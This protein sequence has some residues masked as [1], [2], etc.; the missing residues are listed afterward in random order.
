MAE[1]FKKVIRLLIIC[2]FIFLFIFIIS[3]AFKI[4]ARYYFKLENANI[5]EYYSDLYD[6][7]PYVI[8]AII[9]TESKF[10][11]YA[12]SHKGASGY[13]Q[14]MEQ[15]ADWGAEE[16]GIEDYSYDR[17]FE[18]EINIQIGTWYFSRLVEQ[19]GSVEV[20]LAAYNGGS[21]NVEKWLQD[22]RYSTDSKS[23]HTI[24]F[25]ETEKYVKRV[26]FAYRVYKKL[27]EGVF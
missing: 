19:F 6:I 11:Q 23:L 2:L 4:T 22:T 25:E 16:I 21:G 27:Y 13:M 3:K 7:D 1:I 26:K 8:T 9:H 20:A 18:P 17:I 14:L 5:I 24:P 12:V 10:D 15:T